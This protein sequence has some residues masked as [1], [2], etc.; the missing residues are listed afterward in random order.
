[1]N[2]EKVPARSRWRRRCCLWRK[3]WSRWFWLWLHS[4]SRLVRSNPSEAIVIY[5]IVRSKKQKGENKMTKIQEEP[6][7]IFFYSFAGIG[8]EFELGHLSQQEFSQSADLRF[9]LKLVCLSC[10]YYPNSISFQK[11]LCQAVVCPNLCLM[12]CHVWGAFVAGWLSF[13]G[14]SDWHYE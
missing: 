2:T 1:M 8:L 13:S 4:S 11:R 10:N 12:G 5:L 6:L 3:D 14:N 7:S 9:G